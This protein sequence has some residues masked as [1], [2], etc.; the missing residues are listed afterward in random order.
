MRKLVLALILLLLI[1]LGLAAAAFFQYTTV[2]EPIRARL[3]PALPQS[4]QERLR[5]LRAPEV[6]RFSPRWG[7]EDVGP[8]APVSISFLTEMD[9]PTTEANI[10]TDPS[11]PGSFKWHGKTVTFTPAEPWPL[12][13]EITVR[14][15][16][17]ARSQLYR[18]MIRPFQWSFRTLGPPRVVETEPAQNARYA[19]TD[20]RVVIRF[21]RLM[22]RASVESRLRIQPEPFNMA[23]EWQGDQ[24]LIGGAFRP[25]TKYTVSLLSGAQDAVYGLATE[26]D[27]TWSFTTT[28]RSPY[29]AIVGVGRF[30]SVRAGQ[31]AQLMLDLVNIS[32][33]DF[34]LYRID[35][36]A[37]LQMTGFRYDDWQH[38]QPGSEPIRTWTVE[39]NAPTDEDAQRPLEIDP[40]EPG[41]Y[42][43][44]ATAPEAAAEGQVLIAGQTALA[45]KRSPTQILA[46][47]TRIDDGTPV[48]GLSLQAYN[49][50]G[51]LIAEGQTDEDGLWFTRFAGE[52]EQ[53]HVIATAPDDFAAASD[54]WQ[55]GIEPWQFQ[56]VQWQGDFRPR[57]HR[58]FLY[59]DRPIYR[60][61]QTVHFKGVVRR[62]RA[63][64]YE[65]PPAG[66]PVQVKITN[67]TDDVL[68]KKTLETTAFGSIY[69]SFELSDEVGLGQW[70]LV[71]QIDGEEYETTFQIEE[72]R[73][74]EYAV[75]VRFDQPDYING[76]TFQATVNARY[77]F[78]APAAGA[79]IRWT[80]YA[81]DYD[82]PFPDESFRDL[83]AQPLYQG[84]GREIARGE[85]LADDSGTFVISQPADITSEDRSQVFT[86]EAE[87]T[88]P[89]AQPVSGVASVL[90]HRG[91]FYIG[92]RPENYVAEAGTSTRFSVR[93]VDVAG[94]PVVE[95]LT[96]TIEQ[97]TWKRRK[98]EDGFFEWDEARTP[99][100]QSTVST[101]P[102][103]DGSI[104]FT[105]EAGGSYEVRVRGTDTRGNRVLGFGWL[106]VSEP[107]QL[108][109]WHF[110][111]ND[112]ID[113]VADAR[114]YQVGDTAR[115]LVQSPYQAAT[116][117]VTV[118]QAG[119]L[120][121]RVVELNSNSAT[122]EVPI[123]ERFFPNVYVSTVLIPRG[124]PPGFKVGYTELRVQSDKHR[125][126]VEIEADR[127][128]YRPR[129]QA[130]YT[131]LTTDVDG[132]P[133]SAEVSIGVVDAAI[134]SLTGA[135]APDIVDA[136]YG[137]Q[138]L[139]VRTAGSLAVLASRHNRPENP[140]G[141][142]GPGEEGV[143]RLFPDVAYWNPTVMTDEN[144][145]A[146][147]SF[148]LPDN[149]TTWRATAL[150]ATTDTRVGQAQTDV[151]VTKDLIVRPVLPRFL[152]VGDQASIG[153]I[154]QNFTGRPQSVDVTLSATNLDFPDN[155]KTRSF[156][157]GQGQAVR[158]D[159]P[160]SVPEATEA[161]ITMRAMAAD[162]NDA[163]EMTLPIEPFGEK[164]VDADAGQ[165]D[166]PS[167]GSGHSLALLT[168]DLPE[169]A[170]FAQLHLDTAPS[171]A[172]GLIDALDYL[173]GFP[174]GCVEQ[175]MSRFLPD[176]LVAQTLQKLG[177]SNP[178][179][180]L[181]P[182]EGLEANLPAQVEKGLQRL[183]HFQ[184]FDGGWG[185]WESDDTGAFQ[186]AYVVYGLVQ[187]KRA[188]F[189][190]RDDVLEHG[191]Q[192]L[193]TPLVETD[194]LD[195]K[196]YIT[197]VLTEYGEGDIALARSL[198]DRQAQL[199]P[200]SRAYLALTLAKLGDEESARAIVDDLA[201]QVVETDT[202]AHWT[203]KKSDWQLMSSDGRTTALVL[204][205]ML[206]VDPDN[207]L[208]PKTVRWLMSR[209]LGGYWRTTQE[210]AATIIALTDYLATTGELQATFSYTVSVNGRPVGDV[211]VT[212]ENVARHHEFTVASL[213]PGSN[214]VR[215]EKSGEGTVYF[216]TDLRYVL[217]RDTITAERSANGPAVHRQYLDPETDKPIESVHVGDL[218]RVK[219]TVEVPTDM[220]Y[221]QIEDPLPAGTEAVNFTL[222]TTGFRGREPQYL[223]SHPELRDEKA[224][225][226]S[227]FLW[228]GTHEYS[229]LIRATTAGEFRVRP[230]VA[231][232]MYQPEVWGQSESAV[233]EVEEQEIA[234]R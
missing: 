133:V 42:F 103:G 26:G 17:D 67:W 85:G 40:L 212:P 9:H 23:L 52:L 160:V 194:N 88:D 49:S 149:L 211:Q 56:G 187:A 196:A 224:V 84:Y 2:D 202:M 161:V 229:Y 43:L 171:L 158:V 203:E 132:D 108:I 155:L 179:P 153:A 192:A 234:G 86:L 81:N 92:V 117:L 115:V 33:I 111:N 191:A 125:I 21:N 231:T 184:H 97:V 20:N 38:F 165:T 83:A 29:L 12:D 174:Y 185:W 10:L 62:R 37:Y 89:A 222:Q 183:Y 173:T 221:M 114:T 98:T 35:V 214:E 128:K 122:I 167:T 172:A 41:L 144:G 76:D 198:L 121:Y 16:R 204:Q 87:V 136:F 80:L 190:V 228:K 223:W 199:A 14:V 225:F 28:Q 218:I 152:T 68:Y 143:R 220:W 134:Y 34:S 64:E 72:Y 127:D 25:S 141:G 1:A 150:G 201:R 93:T 215:I 18:R 104:A 48:A 207:P 148:Q 120:D 209:R 162:A 74:P 106:W 189:D 170:R 112:R 216:A 60:P 145:A 32:Q 22:D 105:P 130:S 168:V 75:D 100:I 58:V 233:L 46:W 57:A 107:G 59:T 180:V 82:F 15:E 147:V 157:V 169:D 123:E 73:K 217:P 182:V 176:V 206:A 213:Q 126:N 151:V 140:G 8:R 69:D 197:Y 181:S 79:Q 193:R 135:G 119:I 99:V 116:A 45:L 47:A 50:D 188:G 177:L 5:S 19:Y 77:F 53:I 208:V 156:V 118:E 31:P 66:T 78:G 195:L 3:K 124:G 39:P 113:L 101:D 137:R 7:A 164:V 129:D 110:G 232:P 166:D 230:A 163:V 186:T 219:L 65:Q 70:R 71:A 109:S 102:S 55:Q 227:T 63:G 200:Y 54:S 139:A 91:E 95:D 146:Q 154:V 94:N 142:G 13:T 175:T 61:G 138:P 51:E 30:A 36:P 6:L 96:Y 27:L 178:K 210:T 4:M 11:V 205:A 24:L 44:T 159:W 226:F 131:I 90:V